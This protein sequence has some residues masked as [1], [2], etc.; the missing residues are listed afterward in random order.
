MATSDTA[1]GS[2]TVQGELWGARARD[3]AEVQEPAQHELYPP[4]F[5]AAGVGEGTSLL[6]AGC[7]SGVAAAIAHDRG[8]KV[9]G[10]D[11]AVQLVEIARD[12]VP[13]ADFSVGELEALPYD[14]DSFDVVTGFNAFQYAAD[15][16]HALQ[17]ARRVAR[18]GGTVAI[19]TWGQPEHCEATAIIR[20]LGSLP[21]PP[22]PGA[23]GPQC[24]V[25]SGRAR[26]PRAAGGAD[27]G[28]RR[29]V[30]HALG[31]PRP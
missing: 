17:E 11:A 1:T 8:A 4:V 9:S 13:A 23:P 30:Q 16:V 7:G 18:P 20:A 27:P 12:R 15:P 6:D 3:W 21:P 26:G 5:D 28:A 24:T 22:P 10:I 29:R 14:D 25:R 19:L 31:V 2:A